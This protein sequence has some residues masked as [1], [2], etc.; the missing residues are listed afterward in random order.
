MTLSRR[1]LNLALGLFLVSGAQALFGV[2]LSDCGGVKAQEYVFPS[3]FDAPFI[4]FQLDELTPVN[5]HGPE[6]TGILNDGIFAATF[7]G[8]EVHT[9]QCN[10]K[11]SNVF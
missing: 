10:S 4:E 3:Y 11:A 2:Q 9:R 5:L 6:H 1:I 8:Y 7:H